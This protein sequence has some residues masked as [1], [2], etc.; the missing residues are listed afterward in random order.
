MRD[1]FVEFGNASAYDILDIVEG[2]DTTY[3]RR[4]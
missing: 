3:K 2:Q 1:G 4:E